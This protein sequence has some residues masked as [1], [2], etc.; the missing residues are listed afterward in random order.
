M[1]IANEPEDRFLSGWSLMLGILLAA[2]PWYLG[3]APDRVPAWN[4]WACAGAVIVLSLLALAQVH[5][6]LEYL[7]AAIGLWL[8]V[9]PWA[10]G[11]GGRIPADWTHAGFGL[12]LAI[13]AL[14]ELWRLR[15]TRTSRPV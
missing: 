5:A 2:A 13:S 1:H 11:F 14:S 10:L 12:A 3:F 4:A 8:C 7:T 15:E 6:W 9:A